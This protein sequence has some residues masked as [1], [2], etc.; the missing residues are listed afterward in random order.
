MAKRHRAVRLSI[1]NHKGG[2]GKTTLT[3]NIAAALAEL[4]KR[5]LIV[6]SDP[7]CNATAYLFD[8]AVVDDLLE[9]SD[10]I[11]GD[12]V[13]SAI[14]PIVEGDGTWRD[15]GV[16]ETAIPGLWML[17]GDI[18]LAE[19]EVELS[20]FW[21]ECLQ[22][23]PKGFK[24]VTGL[25]SL[26]NH[27]ADEYSL[28]YICYDTGPNIGYLNRAI[29]LDC[30]YFI[31]PGACDLFSVRAVKTLGHSLLQWIHEWE[32]IKSLAPQ[33]V[34]LLPGR[35]KFVGYI[36]QGFRV[37]GQGMARL[38]SKYHARFQR[39]LDK[40]I[41]RPLRRE[42]RTL[43][44]IGEGRAKLGEIKDFA[45]LVQKAQEQGQPLWHVQGGP[46]YQTDDARRAFISIAKELVNRTKVARPDVKAK[47]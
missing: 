23:R 9:N 28:D 34:P 10:T 7:Q 36:P 30:D 8:D 33:N 42:D 18:R 47:A 13:W 22:K 20:S 25:S 32:V 27:F 5:V 4:G 44:A 12:T 39:E 38:P 14:K 43:L 6:D 46:Q 40:Q 11:R 41:I 37:Y 15:V 24:G 17:P 26:L 35:P 3:V 21:S 16:Y 19:Y 2:V 29:L 45:R 31:V 1:F